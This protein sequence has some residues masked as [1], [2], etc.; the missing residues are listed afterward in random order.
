MNNVYIYDT[1]KKKRGNDMEEKYFLDVLYDIA[2]ETDVTIKYDKEIEKL[3]FVYKLRGE[4]VEQ[5]ISQ[6]DRKEYA[7]NPDQLLA[8]V[9][10]EMNSSILG[11]KELL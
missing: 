1:L 3:Q 6:S 5:T 7:D 8:Y 2:K 9:L 10:E 11:T 4:E